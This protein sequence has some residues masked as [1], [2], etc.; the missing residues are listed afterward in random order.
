MREQVGREIM[1][2][3]NMKTSLRSA[4]A[5][6][7]V[8]K[9]GVEVLIDKEKTIELYAAYLQK[10]V[11]YNRPFICKDE[12]I[13]QGL[14]TAS[15]LFG[16]I[17]ALR[18]LSGFKPFRT[19]ESLKR[20]LARHFQPVAE[21]SGHTYIKE[22]LYEPQEIIDYF[23][24]KQ[25]AQGNKTQNYLVASE[26]DLAIGGWVQLAL[27]EK[28][29]GVKKKRISGLAI[30]GA[31]TALLHPET[32]DLLFNVTAVAE[33]ANYRTLQWLKNAVGEEKA[34]ELCKTR[35]TE[36]HYQQTLVYVPELRHL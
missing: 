3:E 15:M 27:C 7:P 21:T 35:K 5:W 24:T 17:N 18:T 13:K 4:K 16:A 6:K 8:G 36:Q 2:A 14:Y 33:R 12:A 30:C 32:G 29:T 25:V 10:H 34:E 1:T 22:F 28:L 23:T 19:P 20:E 31:V 9:K 26:A 11:N